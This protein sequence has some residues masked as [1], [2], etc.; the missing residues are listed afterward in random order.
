MLNENNKKLLQQKKKQ[1]QITLKLKDWLSNWLPVFN[2]V[3]QLNKPWS[4]E[5]F[6][7]VCEEEEWLWQKAMQ[8]VP[9]A[10]SVP[11]S[12]IKTPE[13]NYVHDKMKAIFQS[14][15]SLRYMPTL[16]HRE[17][18]ETDTALMLTKAA[19]TLGIPGEEEVFL[20]YTRFTPVIRLPFS[21]IGALKEDEIMNPE[22]LCIKPLNYS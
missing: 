4:F 9:A 20:F 11:L 12:A 7:C 1:L 2:A 5:Y 6:E 18:Y 22:N 14:S 13:N 17:A 10:S 8:Q 19:E 3:Q 21:S 16:S 15:L